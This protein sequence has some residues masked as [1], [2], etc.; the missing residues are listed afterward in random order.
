MGEEIPWWLKDLAV[1]KLGD[2]AVV[3]NNYGEWIAEV[4]THSGKTRLTG[5]TMTILEWFLKQ[6]P[7]LE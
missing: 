6:L 2:G 4:V 7:D 5:Q 1:K 3:R